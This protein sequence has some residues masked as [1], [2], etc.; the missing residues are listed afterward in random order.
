[1]NTAR[2]NWKSVL[3][4]PKH[5]V[6]AGI[7]GIVGND[8][9]YILSFKYAPAVQVDLIVCLWPMM[10]LILASLILSEDTRINHI[11]ACILAF[12]GVY[13]LVSS[14]G[15]EGGFNEQYWVGYFFAFM[16]AILWAI[17]IV[18]SRKY[19][20]STP[21]LFAVYCFVG[22][23]FSVLMHVLFEE[24]I[25]PSLD[26]W[27]ILVVMGITTHSLAYYG[28]DYAIKK[29]HFKLLNILPYGDPILSVL[30]L[31]VFGLAELTEEVLVATL[32]VFAAGVIGGKKFRKTDAAKKRVSFEAL[33][34][35]SSS[36]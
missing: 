9:F 11:F 28:W 35:L 4:R 22:A 31:I 34:K 2:K 21:E 30:A 25:I 6:F 17:Y 15:E 16:S 19:I 12:S 20:R 29:G 7:F 18:I 33:A 1:M 14:V 8:I 3:T 24:T 36:E 10:V 27:V 26:Q 13:F 32:M 5:L 23:V